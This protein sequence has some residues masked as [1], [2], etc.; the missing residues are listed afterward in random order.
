MPARSGNAAPRAA[1]R[2]TAR[3]LDVL[4][5]IADGYS[6]ARIAQ[7]LWITEDTVRTHVRRMLARLDARTRAHAVAIAYR[8]GLWTSAD[9]RSEGG[10]DV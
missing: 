3:E 8:D 4:E 2:I 10:E 5:L 1:Q 9:R 7:A 6:T